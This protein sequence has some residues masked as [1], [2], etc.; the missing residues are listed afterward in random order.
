MSIEKIA[1]IREQMFQLETKIRPLSWDAS[2]NQINAAKKVQLNQLVEELN[3]LKNELQ[4]LEQ[5]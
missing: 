4:Q 2:R 3:T 1:E 5:K